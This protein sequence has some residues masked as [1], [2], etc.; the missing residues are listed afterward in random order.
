MFERRGKLLENEI[1]SKAFISTAYP[2]LS[3]PKPFV[4]PLHRGFDR[5]HGEGGYGR[6]AS[7]HSGDSEARQTA[8]RGWPAP[9]AGTLTS[10]G[11]EP[12]R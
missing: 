2:S 7:T 11:R 6:P 3:L 1:Q 10:G 4:K 5:I 8:T 12:I 9:A